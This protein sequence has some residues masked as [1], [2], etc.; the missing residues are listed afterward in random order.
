M[1]EQLVEA[2]TEPFDPARYR[3][4]YREALLQVINAKVEGQEIAAPVPAEEG[5]N[6]VDLM[7]VLEASV[8]A[9]VEQ[10]AKDA[11]EPV[12]V[13]EAKRARAGRPAHTQAAPAAP[14]ADAADE[15]DARPRRR[16]SA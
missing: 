13:A 5:T 7:K 4:E 14:V 11:P 3:D 9:A 15:V 16:R 12:S 6:L 1:A 8:R 2:M 10:R